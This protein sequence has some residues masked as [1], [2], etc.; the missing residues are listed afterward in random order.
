MKTDTINEVKT[1]PETNDCQ[2]LNEPLNIENEQKMA[3]NKPF[4][5]TFPLRLNE[6]P[7]TK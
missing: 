3:K 1:D 6:T 5:C 4:L 2:F 7:S